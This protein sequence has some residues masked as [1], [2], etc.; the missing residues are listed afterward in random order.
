[1]HRSN[2]KLWVP[3]GLFENYADGVMLDM[4]GH[5]PQEDQAPVMLEGIRW[6]GELRPSASFGIQ[7]NSPS[8]HPWQNTGPTVFNSFLNAE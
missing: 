5:C 1:M 3:D 7:S 2:T 8:G 6:F 4:S